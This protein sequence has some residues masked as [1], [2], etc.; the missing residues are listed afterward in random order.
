MSDFYG[1]FLDC[2]GLGYIMGVWVYV[3]V[4]DVLCGNLEVCLNDFVVGVDIL[5]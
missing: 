3:C 2:N 5:I 1:Y 4:M